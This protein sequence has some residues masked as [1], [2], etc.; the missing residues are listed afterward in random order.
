MADEEKEAESQEGK[1]TETSTEERRKRGR[2]TLET[3]REREGQYSRKLTD[4]WGLE[5]TG[6]RGGETGNG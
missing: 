3:L 5:N 2:A 6:E 1:Y 4:V